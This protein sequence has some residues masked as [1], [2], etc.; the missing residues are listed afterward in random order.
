M[1]FVFSSKRAA[2]PFDVTTYQR[3]VS[4]ISLLWNCQ[5]LYLSWFGV[6][7]GLGLHGVFAFREVEGGGRAAFSTVDRIDIRGSSR[8]IVIGR[9]LPH[10]RDADPAVGPVV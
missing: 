7:V 6:D 10:T 1:A 3:F 2:K 4:L 9:E 8:S 5:S